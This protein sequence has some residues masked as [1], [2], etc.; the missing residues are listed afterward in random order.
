[1]LVIEI[2]DTTRVPRV[3][4]LVRLCFGYTPGEAEVLCV[5]T[6]VRLPYGR[7]LPVTASCIAFGDSGN[8][9]WTINTNWSF[10]TAL[11]AKFMGPTW[12]S[13]GADRTQVGP[14]LALWTLLSGSVN[15][16]NRSCF[17]LFITWLTQRT[18]VEEL[19]VRAFW[20]TH[21]PA[22]NKN[23]Y[24]EWPNSYGFHI[25]YMHVS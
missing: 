21:L 7:V 8:G 9:E 19:W 13:S 10:A 16:T 6:K 15:V 20:I 23:K 2:V 25:I 5:K 22:T 11:L 3:V 18:S 14:M 1:M 24:F 17:Y 12:G 4:L